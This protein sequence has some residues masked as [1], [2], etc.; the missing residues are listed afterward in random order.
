MSLYKFIYMLL[1]KKMLPNW[2]KKEKED[3]HPNL[4]KDKNHAT[5]RR[6]RQKKA[7]TSHNLYHACPG[8][9]KKE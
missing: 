6:E 2:K 8:K 9:P 7:P 3:N 4:L 1:L 5:Q